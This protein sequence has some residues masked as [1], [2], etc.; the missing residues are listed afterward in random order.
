VALAGILTALALPSTA[1]AVNEYVIPTPS[2]QPGGITLGPDN[3]IWFV[4]E[5]STGGAKHKVGRLDPTLALQGS[6]D[7]F[8]EYLIPTLSAAPSKI[9]TGPVESNGHQRLWITELG[10]NRIGALDPALATPGSSDGMT[11]WTLPLP[12][13]PDGIAL[14]PDGALWFTESAG[15]K[16]GRITTVGLITHYPIPSGGGH[17]TDITLGP[18]NR[19]WFTEEAGRIGAINPALAAADTSNGIIEFERPGTV[20]SGIA[21]SGASLWFTDSQTN[22]IE[23]INLSGGKLGEFPT[24]SG[25]SG[26]TFGPDGAIW[27]TEMA[28]NGIGRLT[29]CGGYTSF[30]IPTPNSD[31]SDIVAGPDGALWFTEFGLTANKIGRIQAGTASDCGGGGGGGGGGPTPIGQA[32]APTVQSLRLSPSK[33]RAAKAGASIATKVGTTITYRLSTTASTKFTVE[34]QSIGRKKG[35]KCVKPTRRNRK[36]KK[37]KLYKTVRGSFTHRGNAGSNKFKF[38]GRVGG[39]SLKPGTYRLS[40]VATAGS[41]KSKVKQ[42]TFK[43]V[44]R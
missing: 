32:S 4:E 38:T 41:S 1:L 34:K 39:K 15:G 29:T 9:A 35:K 25:P 33:F 44:R 30:P 28:S 24:G 36:A 26:I 20:P 8:K 27:F 10:Q 2:S 19:L 17:P 21:A 22:R 42:A 31:P 40:A 5:N 16:I 18:D 7:A 11:E 37:C 23:Q 43:I 3:A 14:G 12:S 6:P 13:A